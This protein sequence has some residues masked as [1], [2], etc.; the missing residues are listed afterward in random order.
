M[1]IETDFK[2]F[3]IAVADCL[4]A[5]ALILSAP[6]GAKAQESA[7]RAQFAGLT[8][9]FHDSGHGTQIEYNAPNGRS[10]LWYP[11]NSV[12]L[13]AYWRVQGDEICYLYPSSSYN[14]LTQTRGGGWECQSA[15]SSLS[16]T[17]QRARGD[18]FGL[19]RRSRPPFV[20]SADQTTL[21]EVQRRARH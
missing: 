14:P 16:R 17:T 3:K 10:Y 6:V 2:R 8:M 12:V 9:M 15:N 1:A 19:S 21:Q 7:L 11:G 4:L 13:P 18:L 5:A 20:L